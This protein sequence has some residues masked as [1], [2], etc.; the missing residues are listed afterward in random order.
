MQD[1]PR[2]PQTDQLPIDR[3]HA[4]RGFLAETSS[5]GCGRVLL[6][7][8]LTS[9]WTAC[10]L[11]MAQASLERCFSEIG[12]GTPACCHGLNS[13]SDWYGTNRYGGCGHGVTTVMTCMCILPDLCFRY[14]QYDHAHPHPYGILERDAPLFPNLPLHAM[15]SRVCLLCPPQSL[16]G[17]SRSSLS[18]GLSGF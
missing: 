9:V 18:S 12:A 17:R 4:R 15:S 14:I 7:R 6:V 16:R 1:H 3:H 8:L 5:A 2:T 10:A 13:Q 11:L